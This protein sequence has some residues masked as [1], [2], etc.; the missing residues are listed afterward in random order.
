MK[1]LSDKG[2]SS[3]RLSAL[4]NRESSPTEKKEEKE[5]QLEEA[6]KEEK[7]VI[8][9]HDSQESKSSSDS[10]VIIG[11]LP[12]PKSKL[13]KEQ[14]DL[15]DPEKGSNKEM[16][17]EKIKE[18]ARRGSKPFLPLPPLDITR[19]P[20]M[21]IPTQLPTAEVTRI[22]IGNGSNGKQD[23]DVIKEQVKPYFRLLF[24]PNTYYPRSE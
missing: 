13:H 3:E 23:A 16:F 24:I 21:P 7:V 15:F 1:R 22:E 14:V 4:V 20:E 11:M 5:D 9:E 6:Q 18:S 2:S 10:D 19:D 8:L 12:S 17:R